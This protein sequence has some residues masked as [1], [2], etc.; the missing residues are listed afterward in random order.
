[1]SKPLT[2][3][4]NLWTGA[5]HSQTVDDYGDWA[6]GRVPAADGARPPPPPVDPWTWQD[7]GIGWGVVLPKDAAIPEALKPL[8]AHRSGRVL[9]YD[10]DAADGHTKLL[11]EDGSPLDIAGTPVGLG[12]G[13]IPGFLAIV[14]G[15]DTIPWSMQYHLQSRFRVGRLHLQGQALE[16]YVHHLLTDWTECDATLERSLVWSVDHGPND[17][18]S[19][20]RTLVAKPV[21]DAV[22]GDNVYG[23]GLVYL[24][25][26]ADPEHGRGAA[27]LDALVKHKPGVVLSTHHGMTGPLDDPAAMAANLGVPVDGDRALV[28]PADILAGW[29]PSGA[30]WYAHACCSAGC[31]SHSVFASLF[32]P[33]SGLRQVLRGVAGLGAQVAPLPTAL[34]S[35]DK[36]L[37]A[38]IGQVE[39]TFDWTLAHPNTQ[40]EWTGALKQALYDGVFGSLPVGWTFDPWFRGALTHKSSHDLL[41]KALDRGDPVDDELLLLQRLAG[42]DRSST[43]VLG[44]PTVAIQGP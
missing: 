24:D 43:V 27:L 32:P 41:V 8:I 36:P 5:A 38:F 37:R 6:A 35:A 21:V 10:G 9:R 22:R 39:P 28:Q 40:Q 14:A 30:I 31:D 23:P 3:R 16:R 26:D 29:E 19:T 1:M 42:L 18:T 15:P 11:D 12:N 13:K 34:L 17:I 33:G 4:P 20:M 2:L 7:P 25:G 44:D